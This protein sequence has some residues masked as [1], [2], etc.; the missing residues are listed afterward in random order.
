[1]PLNASILF[2]SPG[3]LSAV[4]DALPRQS[5][6]RFARTSHGFLEPGLGAVW[7]ELD[8][9]VPLVALFPAHVFKKAK[10]P[11][12]GLVSIHHL[13]RHPHPSFSAL[14]TAMR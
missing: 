10:R 6:V 14:R 11:G 8:S 3:A 4:V 13:R 9:L 7:R 5:A 1:M 2:T 12:A